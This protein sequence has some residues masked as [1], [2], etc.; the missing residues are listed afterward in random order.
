MTRP[1]CR[2]CARWRSSRS[3]PTKAPLKKAVGEVRTDVEGGVSLSAAMAKH[4]QVFPPLMVAMVRAGETGGFL[5][6]AL[7]QIATSFEKDAA[8]RGKIKSA[9]TYPVIVLVF[10][11]RDDRRRC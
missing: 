8:L 9:L 1:A 10:S 2:C 11:V 7:E 5:D 4:D 6:D 3:R